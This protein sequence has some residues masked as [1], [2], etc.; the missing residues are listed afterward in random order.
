MEVRPDAGEFRVDFD[1][2][3]EGEA[4]ISASQNW[5]A[6]E[7]AFDMGTHVQPVNVPA[8]DHMDQ[9]P[10]SAS[11]APAGSLHDFPD[12]AEEMDRLVLAQFA[13]LAKV[14]V[15]TDGHGDEAQSETLSR[16]QALHEMVLAGGVL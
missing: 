15:A 16:F 13:E 11:P 6:L 14:T 7:P 2:E 3:A 10:A 8:L 1:D 4:W 9:P 12:K 5:R